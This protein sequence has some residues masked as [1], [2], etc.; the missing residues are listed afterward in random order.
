MFPPWGEQDAL[1]KGRAG[2]LGLV[3]VGESKELMI[4]NVY[5]LKYC[6]AGFFFHMNSTNVTSHLP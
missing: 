6:A 4:V 1:G 3:L 2:A 5:R